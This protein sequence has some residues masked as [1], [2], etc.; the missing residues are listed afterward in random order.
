MSNRV[1]WVGF[2]TVV[3]SGYMTSALA[4]NG[5]ERR[6]NSLSQRNISISNVNGR[7]KFLVIWR[8][9]DTKHIQ[10]LKKYLLRSKSAQILGLYEQNKE[11]KQ[12]ANNIRKA[13]FPHVT[14]IIKTDRLLETSSALCYNA[15]RLEEESYDHMRT[16]VSV[17]RLL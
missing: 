3:K 8:Q 4:V 17:R 7:D 15:G 5:G 6:C 11:T 2:Y 9:W 14:H 16:C 13:P 1:P 12:K 10:L